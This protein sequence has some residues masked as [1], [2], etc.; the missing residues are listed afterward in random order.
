MQDD[1]GHPENETTADPAG[2]LELAPPRLPYAPD[3]GTYT[4]LWISQ[5]STTTREELRDDLTGYLEAY[6]GSGTPDYA[7]I[8][9]SIVSSG[10][11]YG[12]LTI[13]PDHQ[14]C[15]MHSLGRHSSGLGRQTAA[16]N[17]F[18]GLLGE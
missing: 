13:L 12:F 5:T 4:Q 15:L 17:R 16:H 6:S 2:A 18:F 9:N 8:Q 10:D 1:D 3:P 11:W 7:A 14:V